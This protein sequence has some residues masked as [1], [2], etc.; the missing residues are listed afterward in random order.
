MPQ[1]VTLILAL[2]ECHEPGVVMIRVERSKL[3]HGLVQLFRHF[4]K[5][6]LKEKQP[7]L[8][9]EVM[10]RSLQLH[11]NGHAILSQPKVGGLG[12]RFFNPLG[13]PAHRFREPR[14]KLERM[15][16]RRMKVWEPTQMALA[17]A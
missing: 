9:I 15:G 6:C 12:V 17:V 4:A 13:L 1:R 16:S 10:L 14:E 11:K 3:L 8:N 7:A 2:N 5:R